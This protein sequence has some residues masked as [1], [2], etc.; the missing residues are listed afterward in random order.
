MER[1]SSRTN[2][3]VRYLWELWAS[4]CLEAWISNKLRDLHALL[5]LLSGINFT[6]P[7]KNISAI[8]FPGCPKCKQII[9]KL[10][11][12]I[13]CNFEIYIYTHTHRNK[14][15]KVEELE[16][17]HNTYATVEF[18]YVRLSEEIL[19][20]KCWCEIAQEPW[21][22]YLY[23]CKS[24]SGLLNIWEGKSCDMINAAQLSI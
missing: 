7:K 11:I 22:Q 15:E 19:K 5:Q 1:S 24:H 17:V 12:K 2:H 9:T 21:Q 20:P 3:C 10:K 14:C 6:I 16:Q 4:D 23:K 18:G 13:A 8:K